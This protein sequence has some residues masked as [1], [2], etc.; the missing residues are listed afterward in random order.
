MKP[1]PPGAG[2]PAGQATHPTNGRITV[3]Y[4]ISGLAKIQ[5]GAPRKGQIRHDFSQAVNEGRITLSST[6]LETVW[7]WGGFLRGFCG[8]PAP[9]HP[10]HGPGRH[11][12]SC[13]CAGGRPAQRQERGPQNRGGLTEGTK[14]PRDSRRGRLQGGWGHTH[15]GRSDPSAWPDRPAPVPKPNRETLIF[16]KDL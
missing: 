13:L 4:V 9:P 7:G 1:G 5:T 11:A 8:A 14:G 6:E 15:A 12:G 2:D 16:N 3:R 10:E